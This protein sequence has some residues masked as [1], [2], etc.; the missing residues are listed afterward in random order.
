METVEDPFG[1]IVALSQAEAAMRYRSLAVVRAYWEAL[2]KGRL[3]PGRAEVDPRGIEQA[4]EHAFIAER[5]A[6][7]MARFRLAGMHLN[8]LMGMEVR[9]MPLS[10]IFAPEARQR[11]SEVLEAVFQGPEVAEIALLAEAGIG[12]PPLSARLLILPLKSDLGDVNRALGC[13]VS[14]GQI[15]RS[16]RRFT[17]SAVQMSQITAGLPVEGGTVQAVNPAQPSPE[18]LGQPG[19]SEPGRAFSSPPVG[20]PEARRAAFRIVKSDT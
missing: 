3:V 15:G 7:G 2:R 10:S 13:L 4:L 19:F 16:P 11:I 8:D 6:P 1:K 9:G 20:T 14:D 12:K 17:I 5:I 18:L